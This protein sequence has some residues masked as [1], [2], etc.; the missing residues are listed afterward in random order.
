MGVVRGPWTVPLKRR[1][2]LLL[3]GAIAVLVGIWLYG[4]IPVGA[5]QV[6]GWASWMPE[7]YGSGYLALPKGPGITVTICAAH[8]RTMRSNDAGPDKAMQRAGRVADIGVRTWEYICGKP[9]STGLCRVTIDYGSRAGATLPP[10]S[11]AGG[12]GR[13]RLMRVAS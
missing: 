12:V 8:C 2:R 11:T 6:S 7:R 10:T 3:V 9:R 13:G 1:D 4:A 5:H